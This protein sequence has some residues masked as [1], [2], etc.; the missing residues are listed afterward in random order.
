LGGAVIA[1]ADGQ[2]LARR[3]REQGPGFALA[4]LA[5]GSVAP[6]EEPPTRYWLHKRGFFAASA[7]TYLNSQGRRWYARHRPDAAPQTLER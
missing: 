2:V 1:A 3:N 7:W 5:V 4:D 6:V